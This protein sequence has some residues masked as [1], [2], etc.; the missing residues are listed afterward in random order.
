MTVRVSFM[1][2][3]RTHN[4]PDTLVIVNNEDSLPELLLGKS[5]EHRLMHRMQSSTGF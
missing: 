1:G 4:L 2:E 3:Q 5:H